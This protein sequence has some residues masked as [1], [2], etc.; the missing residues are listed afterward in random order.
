MRFLARFEN[1]CYTNKA[2]EQHRWVNIRGFLL[3]C[4]TNLIITYF[5]GLQGGY[6]G[7]ETLSDFLRPVLGFLELKL[8]KKTTLRV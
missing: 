1:V 5:R 4:H 2:F 7:E 6:N 8:F 3:H